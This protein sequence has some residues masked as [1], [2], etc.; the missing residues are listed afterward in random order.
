MARDDPDLAVSALLDE[1]GA[2]VVVVTGG[3]SVVSLSAWFGPACAASGTDV[4][5]G[6]LVVLVLA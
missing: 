4:E 1:P 3:T 6:E 5:L 2:G